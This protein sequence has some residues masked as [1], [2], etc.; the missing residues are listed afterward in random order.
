[1]PIYGSGC[2]VIL[3]LLFLPRIFYITLSW[4]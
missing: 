2:I 1:L 4:N 3:F